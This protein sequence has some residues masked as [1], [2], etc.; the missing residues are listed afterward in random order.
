MKKLAVLISNA[1][2]GTNLQAIIDAITQKKLHAK[3]V[4][5]ISDTPDSKGLERAK[6]NTINTTIVPKKEELLEILKRETPDYICLA[7]WK[8]IILD[9]VIS[10]FP[11]RILNV[12]PGLIPDTF[13]GTVSNPDKTNAYWN[14]GK[15]T[16]VAIKNFLDNN[17]T[18][19]GSSIHFLT[20]EFDFGP[21]LGRTF[22]KIEPNDTINSLYTR[23]KKKE[24]EL[25][26]KV[27]MKLCN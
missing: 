4:I 3:I 18:Y 11:N 1:G 26:I 21:V 17:A 5:V 20:M 2:T 15:L 24:N 13:N 27:L 23:L 6:N 14:K 19:A 8:Q 22:E 10:T 25:Y 9:E 7:G 12:H 16:D